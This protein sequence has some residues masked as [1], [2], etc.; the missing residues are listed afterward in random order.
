LIVLRG[1]MERSGD[2]S[3]L[4]VVQGAQSR[5][6]VRKQPLHGLGH[7]DPVCI[8]PADDCSCRRWG[9]ATS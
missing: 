2:G 1:A 9:R 6:G 5:R 8:R 4:A 7:E 3:T